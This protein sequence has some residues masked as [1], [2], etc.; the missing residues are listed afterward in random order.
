MTQAIA[1]RDYQNLIDGRW[2][3]A[4]DGRTSER[5]SPA[6][7]VVVGRYP[8]GGV[9]DLDR[10]VAAARKAFDDG[11][12]PK[13]PGVERARVLNRVAEAIRAS[14]DDLAYVE[15]L[16]SGK[17]ISQALDEI[18]S[19]AD[20]WEYA[21]SLCRHTYGDTYNTLG[22][23]M[24]GLVLREPVGVVG[25]ITPWNFPLLII[26]QKLPVR[27]GRRL[28][29][30]RQACRP[31]PGHHDPPRPD[32]PGGRAPGRRPQRRDR[33]RSC[34]RH[35]PRRAP[36]RRHDQLHR[37]DRRRPPRDRRVEGQPQEGGA[38]ARWQ[39]PAARLCRR[40]SRRGARCR[41]L[42]RLLQ[43]GRVLQ[44]RQPPARPAFHRGRVR[45]A[46]R[47]ARP[48]RPRRRSARPGD[49]G[50][51][52]RQRRA[53]RQDHGARR[54]RPV[55][56]RRPPPGRRP[57]GHRPRTIHRPDRLLGRRADDADRPRGDL[58]AGPVRPDVR[59][60]RRGGPDRE[61]HVVRPVRGCLDP[62]P[63]HR[64]SA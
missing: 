30:R 25:M 19:S 9:E 53:V 39:E 47:R 33:A 10:A 17:P 54:R 21:A 23:S 60:A 31:D 14:A 59:H 64:R 43:H 28:H 56:G 20:L 35:P 27:P 51:R 12:W 22:P 1:A 13:I 11:P 45:R 32:G 42:W 36:R 58:R 41:R 62:R 48:H 38:R 5:M 57:T 52:D 40:R 3:D 7:D 16:E 18:K 46:G 4:A 29:G 55:R 8:A 44:Q 24:F 50:R 2:V 37:F 34:R 26:S 49:Q 63:R 6:H 61:L 15:A